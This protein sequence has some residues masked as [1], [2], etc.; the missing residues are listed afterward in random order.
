MFP[1]EMNI[2]TLNE[3]YLIL[4]VLDFLKIENFYTIIFIE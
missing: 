1:V 2:K 3:R 4:E